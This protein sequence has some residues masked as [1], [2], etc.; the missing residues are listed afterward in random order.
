MNIKQ[1]IDEIYSLQEL[2]AKDDAHKRGLIYLGH[3]LWGDPKTKKAVAKTMNNKLVKI[4][5]GEENEEDLGKAII[6]DF[7]SSL[8]HINIKNSKLRTAI[9]AYTRLLRRILLSGNNKYFV[10]TTHSDQETVDKFL[11]HIGITTNI[12][13]IPIS[14]SDIDTKKNFVEKQIKHGYSDIEFFDRDPQAV[15][16]VDGLKSTYNQ[17]DVRIDTHQIPTFKEA[18]KAPT[19]ND[20]YK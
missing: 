12:K 17:L 18:V 6:L 10:M 4:E 9:Q 8:L 14:N 16:A 2:D 7:D 15:A 1:I 13:F 3:A 20:I 5:P 11:H 19:A